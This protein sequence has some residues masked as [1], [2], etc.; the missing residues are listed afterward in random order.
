MG[1]QMH[2]EDLLRSAAHFIQRTCHFYPAALAAAAGMYLR[3]HHPYCATQLLRRSHRL[4]DTE[5][6]HPARCRH[7]ELTQD[8]LAL[9]FVNFHNEF[10]PE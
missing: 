2:A 4:I 1:N 3:L 8:L 9:I 6:S 7:T 5:T 10:S